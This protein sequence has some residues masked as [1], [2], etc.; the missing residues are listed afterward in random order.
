MGA[1]HFMLLRTSPGQN[2]MLLSSASATSYTDSTAK[3]GVAYVYLVVAMPD[4]G[5]SLGHS[6]QVSIVG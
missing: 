3:V 2:R 1:T 5:S 6:N 4:S